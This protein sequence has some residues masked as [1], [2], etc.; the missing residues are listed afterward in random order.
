MKQAATVCRYLL[1]LVF[2]VFGFNHLV[3]YM[4]APAQTGIAG[5][6]TTA[7]IASHWM[8]VVGLCEVIPGVLLLINLYVPL[9][10][11][12]LGAVIVNIL[13][14]GFLLAPMGIPAGVIVAL[15][16]AILFWRYRASFAGIFKARPV[17]D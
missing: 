5:Q 17:L 1:G 2:V 16:W 10:L 14:A 12:V 9:A 11:T 7:M 8:F 3:P 4:P 13:L 6:F 15:L